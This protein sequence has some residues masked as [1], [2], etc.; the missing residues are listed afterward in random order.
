MTQPIQEP[1]LHRGLARSTW[2]ENQLFRRP[3]P[4]FEATECDRAYMQAVDFQTIAS[5]TTTN[6]TD[7]DATLSVTGS[8]INTDEA[9]GQFEISAT[10]IYFAQLVIIYDTIFTQGKMARI[11]T[12]GGNVLQG[13]QYWT[14]WV[15]EDD[16]GLNV[17]MVTCE[18][19]IFVTLVSTDVVL[20]GVTRQ[21]SGGPQDILEAD[22]SIVKICNYVAPS[23]T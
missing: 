6:V 8:F 1:N 16:P 3:S 15:S 7:Y 14:Q 21:E 9:N 20:Q 2:N 18:A 17:D 23:E 19:L 22:F 12:S 10:G 5:A 4:T 13:S 11:Q